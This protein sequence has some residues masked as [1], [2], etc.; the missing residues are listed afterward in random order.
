MYSMGLPIK[1]FSPTA[2]VKAI[3]DFTDLSVKPQ[4]RLV[5][6]IHTRAHPHQNWGKS[7]LN[8]IM[9]PTP[10]TFQMCNFN[11]SEVVDEEP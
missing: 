5:D 1:R 11:T 9:S 8:S 4:Q 7:I 10:A 2:D 6:R 3:E